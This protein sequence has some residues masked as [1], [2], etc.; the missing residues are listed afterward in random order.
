MLPVENEEELLYRIALTFVKEVGHKRA[1]SLLARF[2][3]A[4]GIFKASPKELRQIEGITEPRAKMFHD[5]EVMEKA[6]KELTF[7]QKHNVSVL[8]YGEGNYPNR[9]MECSDAPQILY[10]QGDADLNAPKIVAI[11]GTRK[12]TEYGTRLTEELVKGLDGYN[13]MLVVSGLA[14]GID[15][16]A[17]KQALQVG[18]PTVGVMGNGLSRIYP[19][20][21]KNL[22]K[23]MLQQGGLLT[24]YPSETTPERQHFPMRNRVVAGMSDVTIVVES[25]I[26]GG[27]MITARVASSYNREVAAFPGR[28]YDKHSSGCNELIRTSIAA[29]ITGPN[30]VLDLMNWN[31]GAKK[32]AVQKQFFIQLSEDEQKIIDMLNTK[33]SVHTDELLYGTGI[34]NSLLA[35]TLL[36]L[37]MQ[38]LIKALPGKH[39]RINY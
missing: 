8:W 38:D 23:E 34:N 2:G 1:Q 10:Y 20:A 27:A 16:L 18:L 32:K 5:A 31:T 12:N 13:D 26:K 17:H 25:D 3:T 37:E 6:E 4:A 11:I 28:V 24:E 19:A 29:M 39:Y 30:D 7:V 21:N 14:H 35:A 15:S 36:Q 9:L 33:D 22:S